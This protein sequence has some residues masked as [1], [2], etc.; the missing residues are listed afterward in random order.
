M[1]YIIKKVYNTVRSLEPGQ[2][3]LFSNV[4]YEYV[5]ELFTCILKPTEVD[6]HTQPMKHSLASMVQQYPIVSARIRETPYMF[7]LIFL[8]QSTSNLIGSDR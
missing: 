6:I 1:I 8:S 2:N 7:Y 5:H 3:S 4:G